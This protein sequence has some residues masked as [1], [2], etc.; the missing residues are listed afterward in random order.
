MLFNLKKLKTSVLNTLTYNGSSQLR[1]TKYENRS[2]K[3][4]AIWKYVERYNSRLKN[5]GRQF[6][7]N[8]DKNSS[9]KRECCSKEKSE[10]R[11]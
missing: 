11:A 6:H 7:K 9:P 10:H 5:L 2:P 4:S 8:S 3:S 1:L